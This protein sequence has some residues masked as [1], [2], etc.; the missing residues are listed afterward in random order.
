MGLLLEH[1]SDRDGS[2]GTENADCVCHSAGSLIPEPGSPS[3]S[4]ERQVDSF[5]TTWCRSCHSGSDPAGQFTL[6]SEDLRKLP[7]HLHA[8]EK[9]ARRLQN[10]DMPP[11]GEPRP[12]PTAAQVTLKLLTSHL[13]EHARFLA[14]PGRTE[15]LRRLTRTEYRNAVRD[16]LGVNVD[17]ATLLPADDRAMGLTTSQ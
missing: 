10:N 5:L 8:W 9:V 13:D 16:L 12:D 6:P 3:Q 1:W 14:R 4:D 7:D 15:S 11:L 2:T 17:V